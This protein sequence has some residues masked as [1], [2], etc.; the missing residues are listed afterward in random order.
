MDLNFF[1]Y[2]KKSIKDMIHINFTL[3]EF[4][5]G[6]IRTGIS[7]MEDIHEIMLWKLTF[8]FGVPHDYCVDPNNLIFQV[9]K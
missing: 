7:N 3:Y 8:I 1:T 4:L 5:R 9:W 2:Q 6:N